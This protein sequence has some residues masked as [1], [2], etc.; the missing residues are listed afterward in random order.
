L[1]LIVFAFLTFCQRKTFLARNLITIQSFH[2]LKDPTL[3]KS[4]FHPESPQ[5]IRKT[6][7]FGPRTKLL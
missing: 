4:S 7:Q 5:H 3:L 2:Y 1:F 6:I